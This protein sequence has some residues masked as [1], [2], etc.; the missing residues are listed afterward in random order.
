[1]ITSAAMD[2]T[3]VVDS[4]LRWATQPVGTVRAVRTQASAIALTFDDG[5]DP[6]HTP[7][8][9]DALDRFAAKATFFV[10]L[11]RTRRYPSLTQKLLDRGHE[12][13]LHGIDH[14]RLTKLPPKEVAR[15][16]S[17]ARDE[18]EQQI[19]RPVRWFRAPYGALM[20]GHRRAVDSTGLVTVN[21]ATTVADWRHLPEAQL[22]ADGLREC[23][24]GS[25]MLVHDSAA[26]P[27]DG[28]QDDPHPPPLDRGLL[29]E[30]LLVGAAERGWTS[31]SVG[32]LLASGSARRWGWFYR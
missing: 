32:E 15:R 16:T 13:A 18:L 26:G 8:V 31:R 21:W 25:I 7:R 5:P 28:A 2:L 29:A 24:Q 3:S 9:L 12:I 4:V 14:T 6:V 11:T 27:L 23:K 10:L 1:M 22:A 30:L 17:A 19:Q 20:P